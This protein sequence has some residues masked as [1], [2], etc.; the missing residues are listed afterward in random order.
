MGADYRK[1]I[2]ITPFNAQIAD[3]THGDLL[4]HELT[5]AAMG[6]PTNIRVLY[7][8]AARVAGAGVLRFYPN[9]GVQFHVVTTTGTNIPTIALAIINQRIQ[10]ALTVIND[11]F[12]VFCMGYIT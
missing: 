1:N 4:R 6:L 8:Y 2:G 3:I 12:D 7:L 9:E 5:L 10:Y 11:D